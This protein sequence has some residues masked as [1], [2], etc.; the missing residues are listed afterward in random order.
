MA[1]ASPCQ[2]RSAPAFGSVLGGYG[3]GLGG[4]GGYGIGG[5]GS[6]SAFGNAYGG[7][8]GGLGGIMGGYSG[9]GSLSYPATSAN[10][11]LSSAYGPGL[12]QNAPNY[13]SFFEHLPPLSFGSPLYLQL[14]ESIKP[15]NK[16]TTTKRVQAQEQ[17]EDPRMLLQVAESTRAQTKQRI[18][19]KVLDGTLRSP[20]SRASAAMRLRGLLQ[21]RSGPTQPPTAPP[22]W[23]NEAV[24]LT[25]RRYRASDVLAVRPAI[26]RYD[27]LHLPNPSPFRDQI[28]YLQNTIDQSLYQ[29]LEGLCASRAPEA[30][31]EYCTSLLPVFH[32]ITEGIRFGDR[33]DEICMRLNHCDVVSSYLST[34]T[35]HVVMGISTSSMSSAPPS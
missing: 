15:N 21:S 26:A 11:V 7:A 23:N 20:L 10:S 19:D 33:A 14:S 35:P 1:S 5:V 2:R 3:S 17:T 30:F 27:T 12:Y 13:P 4:L 34:L 9:P 18:R 16:Q 8:Y 22:A 29:S 6:Y 32:F 28:R 31:L 24:M 25:P